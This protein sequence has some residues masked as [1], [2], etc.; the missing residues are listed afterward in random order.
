MKVIGA[1]FGRSGTSSTFKALTDLGYKCY[2]MSECVRHDHVALWNNF[3]EGD[4]EPLFREIQRLGYEATLD[5]PIISIFDELLERNPDAKV[6]LN[7]RDNP[8]QWIKS[9]RGT[10]WKVMT[11]SPFR[12][13]LKYCGPPASM[14]TS[15]FTRDL[16]DNFFRLMIRKANTVRIQSKKLDPNFRN[17]SDEDVAEFYNSWIE[18]VKKVVP[19]EK[20]LV[21]NVKGRNTKMSIRY[22]GNRLL[23][24]LCS[25]PD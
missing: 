12:N 22:V 23:V 17:L 13:I 24:N 5:F 2:H 9:F 19:K 1:G 10:I 8:K 6:L 16:H 4:Q 20:L 11:V 18:Y 25:I 21:F 14:N 15:A 7:V 3:F